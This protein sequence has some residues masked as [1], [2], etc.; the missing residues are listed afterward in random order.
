MRDLKRVYGGSGF[1]VYGR[2]I[3]RFQGIFC[4]PEVQ[5]TVFLFTKT[6]GK[7]MISLW[8]NSVFSLL[9]LSGKYGSFSEIVLFVWK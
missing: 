2:N 6:G 4:D 3:W 5:F 9:F 8:E 1:A 7:Q